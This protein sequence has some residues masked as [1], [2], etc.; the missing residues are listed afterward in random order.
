MFYGPSGFE[1]CQPRCDLVTE[2]ASHPSSMIW[3]GVASGR[4]RSV[5]PTFHCRC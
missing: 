3:I 1:P 4:A 5:V 2:L